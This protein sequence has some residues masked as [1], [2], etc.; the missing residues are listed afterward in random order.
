MFFSIH[1][2]H[3]MQKSS[4]LCTR[5]RTKEQNYGKGETKRN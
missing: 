5:Y 2:D 1:I 3:N 4:Y